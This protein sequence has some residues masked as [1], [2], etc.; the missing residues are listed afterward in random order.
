MKFIKVKGNPYDDKA[1]EQV[2]NTDNIQTINLFEEG[3]I[4]VVQ[5]HMAHCGFRLN[6]FHKLEEAQAF[7][8]EIMEKANS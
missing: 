2:I 3:G 4:F 1:I 7:L 5:V 6:M 8:E